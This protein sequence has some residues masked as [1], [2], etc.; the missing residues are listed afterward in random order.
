MFYFK[1]IDGNGFIYKKT[2]KN[3]KCRQRRQA[4]SLTLYNFSFI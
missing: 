4:I 1:K 2:D 3:N